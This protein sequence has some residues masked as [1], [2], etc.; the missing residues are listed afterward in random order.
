MLC[1]PIVWNTTIT[2]ITTVIA[3]AE[4]QGAQTWRCQDFSSRVDTTTYEQDGL[5]NAL[6]RLVSQILPSFRHAERLSPKYL[7]RPEEKPLELRCSSCS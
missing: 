5:P 4:S 7:G 2:I 1:E 6:L 3:V